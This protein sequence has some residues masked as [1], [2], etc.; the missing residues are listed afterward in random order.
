MFIVIP[1][2][3]PV[4]LK[5]AIGAVGGRLVFDTPEEAMDA[6][7][8]LNPDYAEAHQICNLTEVEDYTVS[9]N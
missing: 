4:K 7:R 5:N 9:K 1:P 2:G 6:I 8:M 3:Q